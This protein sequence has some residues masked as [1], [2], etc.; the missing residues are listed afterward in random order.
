MINKNTTLNIKKHIL[1]KHIRSPLSENLRSEYNKRNARVI[2]GDTVKVL[3]GEYKN[4]EGKVRVDNVVRYNIHFALGLMDTVE[5]IS[6]QKIYRLVPKNSLL[7]YPIEINDNEKLLKLLKIK[8]KNIIK[9]NKIQ[10]GFHDGKTI[11]SESSYSVGDTCLVKVPELEI[12]ATLKLQSECLAILTR[13]DNAGS[14]G[15]IQ[16]IKAGTFS[17]PKRV[18]MSVDSR[19]LEIP[20]D[21]IMV[22]S[23]PNDNNPKIKVNE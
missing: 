18:I 6:S 4:V 5:L 8:T 10:Y 19:L 15:K 13:G 12:I 2:K 21:M 1:D 14:I 16:E 17:L 3:R 20:I 9:G 7:L 22:V 23:G 11:L